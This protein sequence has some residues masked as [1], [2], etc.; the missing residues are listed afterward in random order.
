[1]STTPPTLKVAITL[2]YVRSCADCCAIARTV[3]AA[4]LEDPQVT[5]FQAVPGQKHACGREDAPK[6][7]PKLGGG[8]T[9]P[10]EGQEAL[11][12][13]APDSTTP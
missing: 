12:A 7:S 9:G 6:G 2:G 8:N 13:H 5:N 3:S 11:F 1:M 10:L 4:A